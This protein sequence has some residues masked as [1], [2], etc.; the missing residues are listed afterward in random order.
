[1][2]VNPAGSL[3]PGRSFSPRSSMVADLDKSQLYREVAQEADET[4]LTRMQQQGFWP[5]GQAVPE[6][7]PQEAEERTKLLAEMA[8]LRK[9]ASLVKNPEKA[10][11][12]ERKRRWEESKKRRAE[13]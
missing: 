4:L 9:T 2:F 11:A 3:S 10:L 8:E 5:A 12:R 13:A 1:M 6:D 7:P